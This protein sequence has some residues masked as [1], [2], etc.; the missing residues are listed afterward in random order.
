[1][2]PRSFSSRCPRLRAGARRLAGAPPDA[3]AALLAPRLSLDVPYP[4]RFR[5][6]LF[7]P[8]RTFW[9]FLAQVLSPD[10]SC[11]EAVKRALAWLA[12]TDGPD[13]AQHL[14]LLPGSA[15]RHRAWLTAISQRATDHVETSDA[16]VALARTP[17]Q[18]L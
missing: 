14:G 9:L 7:P 8:L 16:I 4:V 1:M 10:G 17:R 15:V 11:A 13:A 6:R 5:Q 18:G 12:V 3:L 2:N